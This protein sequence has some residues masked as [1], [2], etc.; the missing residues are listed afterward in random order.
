MTFKPDHA[1]LMSFLES[2]FDTKQEWR[3][4]RG[5]IKQ[6]EIKII[7]VIPEPSPLTTKIL[8]KIQSNTLSASPSRNQFMS[9]ALT[10]RQTELSTGQS[11]NQ[12]FK[13]ADTKR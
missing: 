13:T 5:I 8:M 6:E 3:V 4:N 1:M 7:P 9:N 10:K 12:N 11:F 2:N